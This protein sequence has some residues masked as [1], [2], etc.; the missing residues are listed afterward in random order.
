[1]VLIL[2]SSS[3]L[4]TDLSSGGQL[5]RKDCYVNDSLKESDKIMI[6]TSGYSCQKHRYHDI[7]RDKE[8]IKESVSSIV[9]ES[10]NQSSKFMQKDLKE[11]SVTMAF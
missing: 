6:A 2:I 11:K 7:C 9:V 5:Y 4:T 1:M 10:H 8:S 3:N